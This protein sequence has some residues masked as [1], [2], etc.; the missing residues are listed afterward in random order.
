M[1]QKKITA[2]DISMSNIPAAGAARDYSILGD[3]GASFILQVV[4]ASNQFYNFKTRAFVAESTTETAFAAKI[5]GGVYRG[6]VF[7]PSG[8]S[9]YNLIVLANPSDQNTSLF[10]SRGK[11]VINKKITQITDSV[12]TFALSTANTNNYATLPTLATTTGSKA[13]KHNIALSRNFDVVNNSHD[14]YGFGLKLTRQPVEKDFVFRQTQTVNGAVSSA[15]SVVLDSVDGLVEG[16]AITA[17]SS[18]SL[19][20]TP[21]IKSVDTNSKTVVISSAQT[22]A[23]GITLTFDAI[24]FGNISRATGAVIKLS[25]ISSVEQ[26]LSKTIRTDSDGDLT[27]STIITLDGTYGI[28]KGD[29]YKGFGVDNS[30]SNL[31]TNVHTPSSTVGQIYV[32]LTQTLTAGTKLYFTGSAQTIKTSLTLDVLAYPQVNR[33]INILLDNFITPGTQT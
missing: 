24:G 29:K 3:E 26:Q 7:F 23:D 22:F 28:S 8:G 21:A 18:G 6:R 11:G 12:I 10:I 20:G 17:V 27:P 19:S 4:N 30:S 31:V 2:L 16:M 15:T 1:E 25:S 33:T 13:K 14:D 5:S 32:E 9:S